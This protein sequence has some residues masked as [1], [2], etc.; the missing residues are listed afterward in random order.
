MGARGESGARGRAGQ[1]RSPRHPPEPGRGRGAAGGTRPHTF[2]PLFLYLLSIETN[3]SGER[4]KTP[5]RFYFKVMLSEG[6]P[7]KSGPQ[8][9]RLLGVGEQ[10]RES[11]SGSYSFQG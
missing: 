6:G 10:R 1:P 8:V 2:L 11:L 3:K 4:E 5:A 9:A 7:S